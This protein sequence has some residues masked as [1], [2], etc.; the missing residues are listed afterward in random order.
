V[1]ELRGVGIGTQM[2]KYGK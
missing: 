1:S 2:V